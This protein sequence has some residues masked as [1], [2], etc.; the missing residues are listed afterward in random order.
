MPESAGIDMESRATQGG[1]DLGSRWLQQ[2]NRIYSTLVPRRRM[3]PK[4]QNEQ[5]V[6]VLDRHVSHLLEHLSLL[7]LL[8]SPR[9]PMLSAKNA[10]LWDCG[11]SR[12]L[13][14]PPT[15]PGQC[16]DYLRFHQIQSVVYTMNKILAL[17][18]G[19]LLVGFFR[20]IVRPTEK[21]MKARH[22]DELLVQE[23]W[24]IFIYLPCI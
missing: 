10:C 23:V 13:S 15:S 2:S 21:D 7:L 12:L 20:P 3:R 16:V 24:N 8:N 4:Q 5:Y 11:Y 19:V 14:K 6:Y 17:L 9:D 22:N 18:R 1:N